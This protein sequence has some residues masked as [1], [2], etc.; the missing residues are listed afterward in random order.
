MPSTWLLWD[1]IRALARANR[2]YQSERIF[3]DQSQLEKIAAG[4]EFLDW[5]H[6]ATILDQTNLY[7]NRLQRYKD[8]EQM[9]QV[10]EMNLA[11]D[12]YSDEGSLLDPERKHTLTIRAKTK[13][14]KRELEDFY[15]DTLQMD[16]NLRPMI[17]YLCKF[18]DCP[19]EIIANKNRDGV[20]SIKHMNVYNFTRI[21]T[22]HGDLVGFY[23]QDDLLPEPIF[24][25]PWQTMHLRLTSLENI[26]RPYGVSLLEGSRKAFKQLRL[27]EDGALIYRITRSPERRVFKIPIGTIPA[28]EV[29]EYLEMTARRL[30]RQRFFNP[31][32]GTF[33]ERYSPLTY[34]DDYFLP[35][36]CILM[37]EKITLL[38]GRI[39]T[40][41][42]LIKE[43]GIRR[44]SFWIYS[45]DKDSNRFIPKR[46]KC[47]VGPKQSRIVRVTLDDGSYHQ[48][49][50]D[51]LFYLKDGSQVQ[52]QN[53]KSGDSLLA[54]YRKI[55]K[56]N[57]NKKGSD[58]EH[59]LQPNGIWEPTHRLYWGGIAVKGKAIHHRDFNS[60]NNVFENLEL[61]DYRE[62]YLMHSRLGTGVMR[63]RKLDPILDAKLRQCSRD[64]LERMRRDPKW[65]QA[66]SLAARKNKEKGVLNGI[67]KLNGTELG[68]LCASRGAKKGWNAGVYNNVVC[69]KNNWLYVEL[70]EYIDVIRKILICHR[71]SLKLFVKEWNANPDL[72]KVWKANHCT[73]NRKIKEWGYRNVE[74]FCGIKKVRPK[75]LADKLK[76]Y[77][78]QIVDLVS[79]YGVTK[80]TRLW[81]SDP[82]LESV[83]HAYASRMGKCA[84]I[85]GWQRKSMTSSIFDDLR[86]HNSVLAYLEK[87]ESGYSKTSVYRIIK[88]AG[89]NSFRDVLFQPTNHVVAKVEF[90]DELQDTYC[91]EVEDT[92]N[93]MLS[94]GVIVHNSDGTGPDITTLPGA[95]NLDQIADIVY[96]KKKMV[97]PLKIPFARVGIG[98][99]AG[100][101]N[102][103]SLSASHAEFAKAVQWVQRE[104]AS[105]LTKLGIVHLALRGFSVD[106]LRG[107]DIVLSASSAIEE[108]YRIET[109]K[110]RVDVMSD[111]K[112][113][114]WFPK[115]WIVTHFTDLTPDE[116]LELK[117]MEEVAGKG[118]PGGG[119][120]GLGGLDLGGEEEGGLGE[121]GGEE[122]GLGELGGEEEGGLGE[123]GEEGEGGLGERL[124]LDAEKRLLLEWQKQRYNKKAR[125]LIERWS[126]RRRK[127]TEKD[128]RIFNNFKYLLETK[129]LDGLTGGNNDD[130]SG[131]TLIE[132]STDPTERQAA[133]AE[134]QKILVE[135]NGSLQEEPDE[136]DITPED[137][138]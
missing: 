25:H 46:A 132:W 13:R 67:G 120:P 96:F 118:G 62:H 77:A 103:K 57:C 128:L 2:L 3:Q 71:G 54:C 64:N 102:E 73:V 97:A 126:N 87:E 114:G 68:R 55:G 94:S 10:G 5:Q 81:N 15:F 75:I 104:A 42:E 130:G 37:S 38:D 74:D 48:C 16:S 23:F 36:R 69:G 113:L 39:R 19:Y 17:R 116:I 8:Y 105:G 30:K 78:Q 137:L 22:R 51:H 50:P 124:D 45:F 9:D 58:Y 65:A 109:W 60:L 26:Y 12:L 112:D 84:E 100:E 20:S 135:S 63:K 49:T 98:E 108:L 31:T 59:V 35:V 86:R 122:G 93:F 110:T 43:Y 83:W 115:E 14:L 70:D 133:I 53:L 1:R 111:L 91:L 79:K 123:E 76:S 72:V 52:A 131:Q 95:E 138:P 125:I 66:R 29:H 134:I 34:E 27:L 136:N 7:I 82:E 90:L 107:F 44:D 40:L 47:V 117:E 18:G 56:L 80:A 33:D 4:S 127:Q 99:G 11:L 21:E 24:L 129:E 41:G 28:K 88:K 85:Y 119:K 6:Q 101:S 32:T 61:M 92:H 106:D 121:L 89:Y